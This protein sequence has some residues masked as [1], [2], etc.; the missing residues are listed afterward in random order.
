MT[1]RSILCDDVMNNLVEYHEGEMLAS[2]ARAVEA[3]ILSCP[4][5]RQG[6]DE[7]IVLD[8]IVHEQLLS[9]PSPEFL[10][11]TV[12]AMADSAESLA[13]I[14]AGGARRAIHTNRTYINL[15]ILATAASL[16][17]AVLFIVKPPAADRYHSEG[18]LSTFS[19]N[20]N[21]LG[22]GRILGTSGVAGIEFPMATTDDVSQAVRIIASR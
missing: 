18:A 2:N 11:N 13:S 16:F 14:S 21:F 22:A 10:N 8:R 17:V 3:H 19:R 9:D 7:L 4:A 1:P 20:Q 5:C 15:G 12:N 6:R